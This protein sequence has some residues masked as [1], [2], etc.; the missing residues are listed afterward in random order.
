MCSQLCDISRSKL[1]FFL[2]N[3]LFYNFYYPFHLFSVTSS[4][5]WCRS[6]IFTCFFFSRLSFFQWTNI[7]YKTS[8]C[9]RSRSG[10]DSSSGDESE[11]EYNAGSYPSNSNSAN[12]GGTSNTTSTS[13]T[14]ASHGK[15][16]NKGRWTKEEVN[17]KNINFFIF[18]QF[19]NWWRERGLNWFQ[20][21]NEWMNK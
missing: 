9:F 11:S 16:I 12:S 5:Y 19:N 8:F 6:L 13:G 18:I 4:N 1:G 17:W 14:S 21:M 10:Y 2:I 3:F 7:Y 20:W 15:H